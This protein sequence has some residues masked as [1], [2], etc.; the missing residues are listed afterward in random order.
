MGKEERGVVASVCWA[1]D[2]TYNLAQVGKKKVTKPII[3]AV[4]AIEERTK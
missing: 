3:T 2:T 4:K 1:L